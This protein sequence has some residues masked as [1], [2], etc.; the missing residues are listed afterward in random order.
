M[1]RVARILNGGRLEARATGLENIPSDGP[2]LLVA[3]H[4]HHLFDGVALYQTVP[5]ELHIL[6][7]L[8]WASNRW[9]RYL[10]EAA[11]RLAEWPLVLRPDALTRRADGTR[12][13]KD[14]VFSEN[15]ISGYQRR[16]L[17][18]AVQLLVEG[19]VLLV[20]P[21]GYPNI[22]PNYTPKRSL[23]EFLPFNSGFAVIAAAAAK[24]TG[25][26]I[27]ILPVGLSYRKN[28]RWRAQINCGTIHYAS[29]YPSRKG[30][31]GALENAVKQLSRQT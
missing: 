3:R 13:Q 18:D 30:L 27:P 23:E 4:Y 5:R 22:D 10:M 29:S 20:F 9:V 31:V 16:A 1:Q 8:D 2:A 11:I 25:H 28:S 14:S 19:E 15:D 7:T 17:R 12:L 21:E 6:V 26:E 24:A